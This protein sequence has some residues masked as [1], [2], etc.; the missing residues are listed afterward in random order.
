MGARA[1]T[2]HE[3]SSVGIAEARDR[4]SPIFAVTIRATF[5]TSHSLAISHQPRTASTGNN[6]IVELMQPGSGHVGY[7][8]TG[9]WHSIEEYST[10]LLARIE[11]GDFFRE[12]RILWIIITQPRQQPSPTRLVFFPDGGKC[13]PNS[14]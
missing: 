8:T 7:W 4:F 10:G 9:V 2:E 1:Q 6:L 13:Q 3:N 5:L 12:Q 11:A 14:P